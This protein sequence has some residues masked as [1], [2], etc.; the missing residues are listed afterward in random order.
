M[1]ILSF[2]TQIIF[3]LSGV[4]TASRITEDCMNFCKQSPRKPDVNCVYGT[5][6]K[7]WCFCNE[8]AKILRAPYDATR[9][10]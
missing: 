3:L 7:C 8:C 9:F 5:V 10:C 2:I 6:D 1:R 4:V